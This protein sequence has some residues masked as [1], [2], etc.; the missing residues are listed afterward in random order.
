MDK[1]GIEELSRQI[2]TNYCQYYKE[3]HGEEYWTKGDY[4]KLN[5]A[6]K[7]ADRIQ[8]RWAVGLIQSSVAEAEA[9]LK[10]YAE[11]HEPAA[12]KL[13]VDEARK[14]L[15]QALILTRS[16]LHTPLGGGILKAAE[17]VDQALKK[18]EETYGSQ[19][20]KTP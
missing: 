8:A 3:K 2:H 11:V 18:D 9:D 7:D 16:Y 17:V 14:E 1:M 6:T 10:W 4:D 12:I 13:A 20:R 5:E 19:L 15:R